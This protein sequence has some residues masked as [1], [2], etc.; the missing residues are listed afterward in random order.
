MSELVIEFCRME[1]G[2]GVEL[3]VSLKEFK[4]KRYLDIRVYVPNVEEK[5]IPTKKWVAVPLN[6]TAE[7]FEILECAKKDVLYS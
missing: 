7:F 3:R 2:N 1:R 5:M 6:A 4:G